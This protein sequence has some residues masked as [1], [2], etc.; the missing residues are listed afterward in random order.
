MN[1]IPTPYIACRDCHRSSPIGRRRPGSRCRKVLPSRSQSWL[2][3]LLALSLWLIG[4]GPAAA[5]RV[6]PIKMEQVLANA[7]MIIV[8]VV[9]TVE[10]HWSGKGESMIGT[11]YTIQLNRVVYDATERL[12]AKRSG[13]T[14]TLSF[15]GGEIDGKRV[16]LP[17]IPQYDLG[18]M[19]ILFIDGDEFGSIS[20]LVNVFA[21][22]YRISRLPETAGRVVGPSGAV[23]KR[24]FFA[25][26]DNIADGFTL[27]EFIAEIERALPLALS[28]PTLKL[29]KDSLPP[30]R[31][32]AVHTGAQIPQAQ[33]TQGEAV[34]PHSPTANPSQDTIKPPR[35]DDN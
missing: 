4:V 33:P 22:D 3:L 34:A 6:A 2:Y 19:V 13:D 27:E 8:G 12:S 23:V 20:P 7:D 28:D 30:M 15:A 11:D 5:L 29:D 31:N 9:I 24:S 21:G 35:N 25:T 32:P 10:S 16:V 14:I 26:E 1:W 17:G 18:E